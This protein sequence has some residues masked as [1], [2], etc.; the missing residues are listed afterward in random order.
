M[1]VGLNARSSR[2]WEAPCRTAEWSGRWGRISG[3][4]QPS[5]EDEEDEEDEKDGRDR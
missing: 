1:E 2:G 4:R 3:Q 5:E